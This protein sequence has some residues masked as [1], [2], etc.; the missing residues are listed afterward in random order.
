MRNNRRHKERYSYATR[1]EWH[2]N[3][4]MIK[5]AEIFRRRGGNT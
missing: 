3:D 2:K 5:D 4:K 1:V